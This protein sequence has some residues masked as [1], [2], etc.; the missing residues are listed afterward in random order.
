MNWLSIVQFGAGLLANWQRLLIYAAL[1]AAVTGGLIGYGYMKGSQRL[2]EYQ[3][4]E[5]RADLR[6][7]QKRGSVTERIVTRYVEIAGQTRTV[8]EY[9]EGENVKYAEQNSTM[10]LDVAWRRLHDAAAANRVPSS[11]DG[12]PSAIGTPGADRRR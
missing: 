3:A 2:Y 7:L 1:A 8:T 10:C 6:I 4:A 12:M 11:A 9:I 5:A